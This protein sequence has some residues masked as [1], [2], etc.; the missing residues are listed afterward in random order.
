ME[1]HE[2]E[3]LH[4]RQKTLSIGQ[5]DS[6]CIGKGS[7]PMLLLTEGLVSKIYE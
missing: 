1:P 7:L 5:N 4:V 3:K 2:T 6:L